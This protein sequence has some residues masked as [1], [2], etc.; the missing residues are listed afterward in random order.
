MIWVL[1]AGSRGITQW[2]APADG[3]L[4]HEGVCYLRS[5]ASL[6]A[7]DDAEPVTAVLETGALD[8]G[9]TASKRQVALYLT[10]RPST[11]LVEMRTSDDGET[12]DAW[13]SAWADRTG[14]GAGRYR[15]GRGVVGR[16]WQFRVTLT[17]LVRQRLT[18]LSAYL[19]SKV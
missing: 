13:R 14:G 19:E 5:G 8:L 16:Y 9:D 15:V 2:S 7:L 17:G 4:V 6:L 10:P 1:T 18:G 12:F 3:L 11:A